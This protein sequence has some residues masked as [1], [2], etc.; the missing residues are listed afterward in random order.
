MRFANQ[1]NISQ[2]LKLSIKYAVGVSF[3]LAILST[4]YAQELEQRPLF[5]LKIHLIYTLNSSGSWIAIGAGY[6]IGGRSIVDDIERD[7]RISSLRL[8]LVYTLPLARGHA[9]KL[10]LTS[11]RRFEKGP[12]FDAL[13]LSYQYYW[14][15]I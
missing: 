2:Y 15:G 13:A 14:G 4:G 9:L 1:T 6:G 3:L 11:G 10:G 7:T 8:G 5:T 12:D